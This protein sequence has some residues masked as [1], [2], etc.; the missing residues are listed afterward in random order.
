VT[1]KTDLQRIVDELETLQNQLLALNRGHT[2]EVDK[3]HDKIAAKVADAIKD[4][5]NGATTGD[6]LRDMLLRVYWYNPRAEERYRSVETQLKGKKGEFVL[7]S[8][9]A[10]VAF[11]FHGTGRDTRN[12]QCF[13][14]GVLEGD[15][16][17]LKKGLMG[18]MV[19]TLPIPRY[20][21]GETTFLAVEDDVKRLEVEEKEFFDHAFHDMNPPRLTDILYIGRDGSDW[22][23]WQETVIIGDEAVKKWLKEHAMPG[24]YKP[25]ADLLSKLILEPT[26]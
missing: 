5:D 22:T 20:V 12:A 6:R 11:R 25:A 26:A 10:Q 9:N 17:V 2:I 19:P 23:G 13:R 14:L 24:L 16:L 7:L 15:E 4:L 8:F 21:Y 3:F 18:T 1:Q